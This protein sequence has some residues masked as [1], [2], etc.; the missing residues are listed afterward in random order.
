MKN[1]KGGKLL[2]TVRVVLFFYLLSFPT[3]P[4]KIVILVAAVRW[5]HDHF[6]T[7]S[8]P[9]ERWT[10]IASFTATIVIIARLPLHPHHSCRFPFLLLLFT[11]FL[12]GFA[13][14]INI[15]LP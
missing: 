13:L 6:Y 12:P 10:R 3:P 7:V 1:G 14:P 5:Q 4:V 8:A 11:L 9:I 15:P 2:S